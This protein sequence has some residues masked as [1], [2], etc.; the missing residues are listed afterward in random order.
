MLSEEEDVADIME[1]NVSIGSAIYKNTVK[2]IN[3]NNMEN[4]IQQK[5]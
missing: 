3:N 2:V 1:K 4:Y 5:S